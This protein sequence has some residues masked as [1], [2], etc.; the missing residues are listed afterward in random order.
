M[1]IGC[2]KFVIFHLY[3]VSVP[4]TRSL[5]DRTEA[6]DAFNAGSIPVGCIFVLIVKGVFMDKTN[7]N[8]NGGS[9]KQKLQAQI[10]RLIQMCKESKKV[11]IILAVFM[12]IIIG[13]LAVITFSEKKE[14]IVATTEAE[15][16]VEEEGIAVP[17]EALEKD[18]Y[19][20]VNNL[21]KQYYQALV[22]G[23]MDTVKSIKSYVDEEE[24]LKIVKKSEFIESYPS[25]I[26]HTKKGPEEGSFVAYVQYEV[27]FKDI[28]STAPGLNTL[29]ICTKEDGSYYINSGELEESDIEYLKTISVQNDVVDLFNTVQVAYNDTKAQDEN[30]SAFLDELPNLLAEAVSEAI[31]E[32]EAAEAALHPEEKEEEEPEVVLVVTKVKTTD[33][34]NV[35]SSD[36]VEADKLGKTS[37]G[38]VLELVEE[39]LNGWS[40]VIFEG[41]EGFIKS[42][43]L[44]AE[45]TEM[46]LST[47]VPEGA[48]VEN[49]PEADKNYPKK[50]TVTDAVNVRKTSSTEA[51]IVGILKKGTE[52]EI[53]DELNNGW[54]KIS[55]PNGP[56][57]VKSDFVK[58]NESGSVTTSETEDDK[59]EEAVVITKKG[60]VTDTVNVRKN[61]STSANILGILNKGS[62]IKVI[63][64]MSN[65]WTK[66]EH[67][68]GTA[69]IKSDYVEMQ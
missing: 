67:P 29:Y 7:L 56:A 57:F 20:E 42:E 46:Q 32:Q 15:V 63:E 43:F 60:K 54:T 31:V 41:K 8:E 68:N 2:N 36:S 24:E 28:E 55:H 27:K 51:D 34:V 18:A 69:Y 39:R 3:T 14:E 25:I 49:I 19:P 4:C 62:E 9:G 1:N 61:A 65:G 44:Q 30:L 35:R 13:A 50:G 16:A 33:V 17:E 37:K 10:S 5:M 48:S 6:S 38:Q 23:D 58:V 45:E 52:I 12:L 11:M 59:K 64:Q 26:V 66:I 40:K 22:D 21:I 47:E 53:L